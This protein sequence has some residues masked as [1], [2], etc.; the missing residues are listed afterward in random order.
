MVTHRNVSPEISPLVGKKLDVGLAGSITVVDYMGN[1]RTPAEAARISYGGDE[2][3]PEEDFALCKFLMRNKHTSP[4]E[5]CRLRLNI[6][7]P[8]F[9][10]RQ[11]VRHRQASLNEVSFRYVSPE[12]ARDSPDQLDFFIPPI[13]TIAGPPLKGKNKQGR[14]EAGIEEFEG[15]AIVQRRIT[16]FQAYAFDFYKSLVEGR[17]V[18]P[19]SFRGTEETKHS[20]L[21]DPV[22]PELARVVLPL[23]TFT[24]IT[25][26]SD[27][28]NLFHFLRL[29]TDLHAQGEFREYA[30]V[31]SWIVKQWVPC[32]W[33][34][35]AESMQ[36]EDVKTLYKPPL[37]VKDGR[38]QFN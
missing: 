27:L 24:K 9:V 6:R 10:A 37:N 15:A 5:M 21:H 30:N 33:E 23:G 20:I 26:A 29:R 18:Y 19:N 16:E 8:I 36:V 3:L 13:H 12:K 2:H 17:S 22:T 34:A 7:L 11:W 25:W 1:D 38:L 32:C 4:F 14:D 28:H 31:I 35:W